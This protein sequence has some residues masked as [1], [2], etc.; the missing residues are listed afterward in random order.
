MVPHHMSIDGRG[1]SRISKN[2]V[3]INCQNQL[4]NPKEAFFFAHVD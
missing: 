2:I 4:D 3:R 1:Q